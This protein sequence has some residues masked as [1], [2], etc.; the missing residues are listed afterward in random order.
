VEPTREE[1]TR[2]KPGR[3]GIL[4]NFSLTWLRSFRSTFKQKGEVK[5]SESTS[6][7]ANCA[8]LSS[9]PEVR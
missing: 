5:K 4:W 2:E 1:L 9:F 6:P 7:E 8:P 3:N